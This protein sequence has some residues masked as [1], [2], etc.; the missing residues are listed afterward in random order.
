VNKLAD[1]IRAQIQSMIEEQL[2]KRRSPIF[3]AYFG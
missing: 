3:S 2:G 1:Q